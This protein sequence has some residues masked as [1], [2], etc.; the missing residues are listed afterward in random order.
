VRLL[1]S[2]PLLAIGSLFLAGLSFSVSCGSGGG[3]A[4]SISTYSKHG[5][6]FEYPGK[7]KAQALES[8]DAKATNELWSVDGIVLTQND[9]I[10]VQGYQLTTKITQDVFDQNT[11]DIIDELLKVTA[12]HDVLA[13]PQV[14]K[15]AGLPAVTY[16]VA[17]TSTHGK[18]VRTKMYFGFKDDVEYFISCQATP[19]KQADVDKVCQ[20]AVDTIAIK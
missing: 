17:A 20:R 13:D 19:E 6:T 8:N 3:D 12:G 15:L 11:Q 18:D 5:V 1:G 9:V 14:T 7:W 16:D 4:N 2:V 10:S